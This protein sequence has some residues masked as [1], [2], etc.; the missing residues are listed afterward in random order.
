MQ[1]E[2]RLFDDLARM[3]NGAFSSLASLRGEAETR[4]RQQVE[5]ILAG[6]DLVMRDEFEAVKAMAAKAREENEAL[7]ARLAALEKAGAAAKPAR[8]TASAKTATGKTTAKKAPAKG[9]KPKA[10]GGK[11]AR[12][13]AGTTGAS[14]TTGDR[15]S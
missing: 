4:M 6:M 7:A 14:E 5:K 9:S 10:A 1:K 2:S 8:S 3:A 12:A 13:A 11:S 15:S